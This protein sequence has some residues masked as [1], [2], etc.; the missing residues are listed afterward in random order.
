[1]R[2]NLRDESGVTLV[3]AV[4]ILS[5]LMATGATLVF[6]ANAGAR[7]AEI[8]TEDARALDL[9]EAGMN[10]AR[11]VLWNASDPTNA[12]AVPASSLTLEGG[13][14]AYS[15]TYN[16]GTQTWTLTGTGTYTNPAGGA[17]ISR[18][19]SSDVIVVP[20]TGTASPVWSYNYS[21]ATSGCLTIANNATFTAPLYVKGNLCVS[22]NA[23]FTG[24]S[25]HVGGTLTVGNNGSV[26][27][28]ATPVPTVNV[29]GGCT[30][31]SPSP[32]PCVH[33]AT[34]KVWDGNAVIT[35][36]ASTLTK[37][38]VDLT[39]WYQNASP[40][41]RNGCT[42][43]SMPGGFDSGTGGTAV[44][45]NP[46]RSRPTF[47]LTPSTAYSCQTA[48]GQLS[49][50]PGSPGTL[51]I[52]GTIFFD[53]NITMS[54]N[55]NAV[56]QGRATIYTS[57]SVTLSNNA[58]LCG[59]SG[60]SASWNTSANYLLFVIGGPTGTTFTISNNAIYQGAAYVVSNYTLVNNAANWGPVVAN[61]LSIANNSGSFIPLTSLPPGAPGYTA[62]V[63][64]LQNVPDSYR[65]TG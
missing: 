40:G 58:K 61:Q 64:T 12:G 39:Y 36:T 21:D 15:G 46:N 62:G 10:Y 38:A 28:S 37:P 22:N 19:V 26:G 47:N 43:G 20:G 32:H 16:S 31:G 59:I 14:A 17:P 52:N 56:Y 8:S 45:P 49:W 30:G 41:P 13:T 35:Q 5:V 53:G 42:V 34:D 6:Y 25:L 18:T 1:M 60:C 9:A 4:C 65:S 63:P 7:S 3:M 54:N 51:T 50:A 33:G 23:H 57:G 27:Y 24:S 29:A 2:R 44:P 48:T 55:A 11:S